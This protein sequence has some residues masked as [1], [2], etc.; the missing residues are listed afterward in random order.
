MGPIANLYRLPPG[1]LVV[2]FRTPADVHH[3]AL[4]TIRAAKSLCA[5]PSMEA[6][7]SK[8]TRLSC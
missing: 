6:L 7:T 3:Q 2:C 1:E 8:T 4:R 5:A